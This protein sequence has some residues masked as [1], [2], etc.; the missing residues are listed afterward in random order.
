MSSLIGEVAR[1]VVVGC[2]AAATHWTVAV[3][4]VEFLGAPPL[5]ANVAGWLV[6]FLVSFGGHYRWTFR[7]HPKL[8][9]KA[10]R[11]FFLVS[12]SGFLVN[13]CAYAWLL[14]TTRLPYDGLLA[15]LLIAVAG[16]TFVVSRL[17]AF[18][19]KKEDS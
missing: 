2:L 4:C 18:R 17:W 16:L 10:L 1:F 11:R 13:E 6:A 15:A 5:L 19:H 8:L 12:A 7:H 3:G 14:S 9:L